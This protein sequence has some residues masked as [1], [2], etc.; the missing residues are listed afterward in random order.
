MASFLSY[1]HYD[2]MYY[3]NM[4]FVSLNDLSINAKGEMLI[5]NKFMR[6]NDQALNVFA[7]WDHLC[8][9]RH[10]GCPPE[11]RINVLQP[12]LFWLPAVTNIH[13]PPVGL[14]GLNFMSLVVVSFSLL[15][16]I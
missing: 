6:I 2:Q 1:S 13:S 3:P 15:V 4:P 5:V 12:D 10:P 8:P 11:E 16:Y 14:N 7:T 9:Q